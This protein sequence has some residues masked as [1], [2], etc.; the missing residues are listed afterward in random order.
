MAEESGR[1]GIVVRALELKIRILL[2]MDRPADVILLE[3]SALVIAEEYDCLP[4][5]WCIRASKARAFD[6]LGE[7]EKASQEY[8]A[9]S[10]II[11]QLDDSVKDPEQKD[12]FLSDD[13]VS[14]VLEK[15][16]RLVANPGR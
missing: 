4:N 11:C 3:D 5:V 1:M 6:M 12:T 2:K 9:A 10:T 7:T 15:T 14:S 13:T 8:R 16:K